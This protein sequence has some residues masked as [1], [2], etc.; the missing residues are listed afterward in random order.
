MRAMWLLAL[1]AA[2]FGGTATEPGRAVP[3]TDSIERTRFPYR[4]GG[5]RSVLGAVS[6]PPAHI[7]QVEATGQRDWP[8]WIKSGLVVRAGSTRVTISVPRAWRDRAAIGWGNGDGAL[9][10]QRIAGCPGKA[11]VGLA[12]AGGFVLRVRAACLPLEFRVSGR[13][14]V[15]RFG[16]GRKCA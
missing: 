13:I 6:V 2:A 9:R 14:A 5:Y 10:R 1:A 7:E 3:C 16:L 12:Y 8:Y 15:V 4:V 11:N